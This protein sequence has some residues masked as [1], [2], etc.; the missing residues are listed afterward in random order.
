MK[1]VTLYFPY[2]INLKAFVAEE[3]LTDIRVGM[4]EVFLKT[5]LT[6][7]QVAKACILYGAIM[8]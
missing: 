8:Q 4:G 2:A 6:P 7:E 3:K 1:N 5:F